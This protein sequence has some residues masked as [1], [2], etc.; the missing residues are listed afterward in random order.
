MDDNNYE[1]HTPKGDDPREVTHTDEEKAA[2]EQESGYR[3]EHVGGEAA[4]DSA[5]SE[6]STE[7]PRETETENPQEQNAY[8]YE[9]LRPEYRTRA[10]GPEKAKQGH[11][12]LKIAAVALVCAMLGGLG[13]G[14]ISAS[15]L[16]KKLDALQAS[17]AETTTQSGS[18]STGNVTDTAVQKLA[19]NLSTNVGDKS[20]TPSEVYNAYVESVVGIANEGTTTNVFGQ[21][22][23]SASSG[24]GFIISEDGYIVTNYHVIED[25]TKLTVTLYSGDTYE[26]TVI[27]YD[28]SNDVALLKIDATGLT[29]VSIGD[30]D[31][32]QVGET[33]CAIGN[34]LGELTYTLTTGA[35]SAKDREVN[36]DGTPI[37]ML[38]TDCAI[39]EGNSGGPLFD[40]N[41]NVIGITTAK[42]YGDT[43]EGIGFAIPINDVMSIVADLKEYGYVKGRPYLGVTVKDLDSD[44]ASTYGLPV[45]AYV[46]SVVEGSCAA[47]AGL[48]QGDIITGLGD[49]EVST[50]TDLVAA[51]KNFAAGDTTTL[52]V[53]RSGSEL[54][55]TI[56]LD[57]KQPDT[58]TTTEETQQ[59]TQQEWS[60]QLPQ[61]GSSGQS[62]YSSQG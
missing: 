36:T 40:M 54:T 61:S 13:G 8:A 57:E 25:A 49:Y 28:S 51:L 45:G 34:P 43:I 24:S 11:M 2:P 5:A 10:K 44:T 26:A 3:A 48:Q 12:G 53:Y 50:Y 23:A 62:P 47:T 9:P 6:D 14:A 1:F 18:E 19:S 58:T 17:A 7:N 39:N 46:N 35:I 16:S 30:S 38:Q 32:L 42:Y 52:K 29:P 15:L 31:D 33:V 59:E 20:L 37:S 21:V 22:S 41:G 55:L 27:G 56:T 4:A 60:N